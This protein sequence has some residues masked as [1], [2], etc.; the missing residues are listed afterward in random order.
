MSA[1]FL[2]EGAPPVDVWH[3][4]GPVAE[5]WDENRLV[6]ER[7]ALW[8]L[9]TTSNLTGS[10]NTYL[11]VTSVEADTGR[12]VMAAHRILV[13]NRCPDSFSALIVAT[14]SVSGGTL[15][16]SNLRIIHNGANVATSGN[17]SSG[18]VS[19]SATRLLAP[20]DTIEMH[21]RGEGQFFNRPRLNS[22]ATLAVD[23]VGY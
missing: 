12:T 18:T 17:T 8:R 2:V 21:Y 13:P 16:Q 20:G 14:G 11:T 10:G 15:P 6:W 7:P 4:G 22:G 23:P 9:R 3:E 5:V 1:D 19:T